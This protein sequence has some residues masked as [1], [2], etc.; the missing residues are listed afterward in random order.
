[1]KSFLNKIKKKVKSIIYLAS[2]QIKRQINIWKSIIYPDSPGI[3][4]QINRWKYIKQPNLQNLT[5]TICGNNDKIT[6]F[7]LFEANDIFNAGK[8][9]RYEC[10]SCKIIFGDLRFLQMPISEIN[11]DYE[12]LYSYY[13]EGDTTNRI[14]TVLENL[15][16]FKDKSLKYLD[17][18]CGRWNKVIPKLR[19]RG[20]DIIGYDKYVSGGYILNNLGDL[21]F[22]VIY[23]SDFIEH[24][25]NPIEDIRHITKNLKPGGYLIFITPCFEYCIDFSH[26][27]TF[28]FND[29]SLAHIG[30]KLNL[31]MTFSKK[32]TF[33]DGQFT[34]SKVFQLNET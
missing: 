2:K 11:K 9:I 12:D 8:L 10:P 1:M 16:F 30:N 23:N 29:T 14:L 24:L 32:F 20:Y 31:K 3:K 34:I 15:D 13:N 33:P 6:N 22:D 25:I 27:H 7:K 26:Y 18:A 19:N 17:Y 5:C 28:Y 4:R 21:K